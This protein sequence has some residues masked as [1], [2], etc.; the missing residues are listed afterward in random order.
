MGVIGGEEGQKEAESLFKE[1]MTE[2]FP[3]LGSDTFR[4]I[5]FIGHADS[6]QRELRQNTLQYIT[7]K[8]SRIKKDKN[9]KTAKEKKHYIQ[10][11]PHKNIS[12]FLMRNLARIKWENIF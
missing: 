8:L 6:T 2:T 5:R 1:I 7:I 3:N 12:R 11:N 4:Y 10:R 9:L